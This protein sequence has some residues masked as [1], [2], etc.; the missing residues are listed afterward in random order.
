MT[1]TKKTSDRSNGTS[2]Y[3][4]HRGIPQGEKK[5]SP[6]IDRKKMDKVL[7]RERLGLED[8]WVIPTELPPFI[9]AGIEQRAKSG[10]KMKTIQDREEVKEEVTKTMKKVKSCI[11]TLVE[12]GC[13][14]RLLYFCLEELSPE[15]EQIRAGRRR[16]SVRREDDEYEL[17]DEREGERPS[18]TRDDME[19]VKENVER[20]RRLIHLHQ[21]ELLRVAETGQVSVPSGMPEAEVPEYALAL[22]MRS[23]TWVSRLADSYTASYEKK[24]L[25]AKGLLFLT[26]YV[27]RYSETKEIRKKGRFGEN[28]LVGLVKHATGKEWSLKKLHGRLLKFKED[29]HFLYR[30]LVKRLDEEHDTPAAEIKS[31][32]PEN[33]SI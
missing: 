31:S 11:K 27:V 25:E 16:M 24:I 18:K 30:L 2:E 3:R 12:A 13:C 21:R 17:L 7:Y 23:L 15:A 19:P 1:D 32:L 9:R 6:A 26:A 28:A 29:Q 14:E 5:E 4:Q 8:E 20:T 22:L 10:R 33:P